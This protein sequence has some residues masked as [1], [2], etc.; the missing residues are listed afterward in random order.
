MR[1][2]M[3]SVALKTHSGIGIHLFSSPCV[4]ITEAGCDYVIAFST[5]AMAHTPL[6]RNWGYWQPF[7]SANISL[8][9][10]TC[11]GVTFMP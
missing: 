10:R 8:N 9:D 2:G 1:S 6:L 3:S 7:F 4:F 11:V 5:I